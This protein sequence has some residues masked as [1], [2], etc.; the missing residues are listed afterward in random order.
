[1]DE[2]QVP[3]KSTATV[4]KP[5][6]LRDLLNYAVREEIEPR[7]KEIVRNVITGTLNMFND[8]ATKSVDKWIYPEGNSPK[9]T[10][11]K[12]IGNYQPHTNYAT[13][14]YSTSSN[15]S[16]KPQRETVNTRSSLDVQL[17]WVDNERDANDI[18]STLLEEIDNYGKAK[19]ATYYEKVSSVCNVHIPTNFA[20]FKYGWTK[21]ERAGISYF[22]DRGKYFIDLPKP[23][24]IENIN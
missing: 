16:A 14:V 10:T 6:I 19:V 22:R 9:R 17:V 21:E 8:A 11:S 3:Q 23:V 20:D 18:I 24:N 15:E 7:S 12:G 4:K 2:K 1:M 5:S 13:R